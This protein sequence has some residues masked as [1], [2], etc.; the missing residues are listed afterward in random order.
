MCKIFFFILTHLLLV[1]CS[2][3]GQSALDRHYELLIV[4]TP[5]QKAMERTYVCDSLDFDSLYASPLWDS[6]L[7]AWSSSYNE[8][9]SDDAYTTILTDASKKLIIRVAENYP[10][11]LKPLTRTLA[12]YLVAQGKGNAAASIAAYPYGIDV[13]PN[14]YSEIANRLLIQ[15]RLTG[16]KAPPITGLGNDVCSALVIFYE[17]DCPNCIHLLEAI[18]NHFSLLQ[19]KQIRVISLSSDTEREAFENFALQY[20]WKDKLCDLQGFNSPDFKCWGVAATPGLYYIDKSGIV[21]DPYERDE[22]KFL[23]Q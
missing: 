13:S 4:G 14:E 3:N 6:Y 9:L 10:Q 19:D 21:S 11:Q 20:P 15:T 23:K 8:V 1:G 12:D 2:E 22:F 17:S 7:R 5:E 16:N 18:K